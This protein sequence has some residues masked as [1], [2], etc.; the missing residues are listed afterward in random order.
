MKAFSILVIRFSFENF[1]AHGHPS[2]PLGQTVTGFGVSQVHA[3]KNSAYP[4]GSI[5]VG[6]NIG[7]EEYTRLS[8]PKPNSLFVVPEKR[9]P[10][11]PL[12]EYI[13]TLGINGLTVYA[14]IETLVKFKKDQVVYISS[15]AG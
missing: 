5:V 1:N 6:F 9:D 4:V 2:A 12:T 7:W 11:V 14:A 8:S 3:S 10:R 15:A 13:D